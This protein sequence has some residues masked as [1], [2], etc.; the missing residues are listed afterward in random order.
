MDQGTESL[1]LPH[2]LHRPGDTKGLQ[3]AAPVMY[4]PLPTPPS[5]VP[6]PPG[7]LTRTGTVG[8]ASPPFLCPTPGHLVGPTILHCTLRDL[9]GPEGPF[10]GAELFLAFFFIDGFGIWNYPKNTPAP[11][12]I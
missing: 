8:T 12:I 11:G 2:F 6:V 5:P 10:G 3:R 1:R 7:G 9:G 4:G